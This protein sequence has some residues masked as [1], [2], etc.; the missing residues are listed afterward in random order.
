MNSEK[1]LSLTIL[2]TKKENKRQTKIVRA[3]GKDLKFKTKMT[4]IINKLDLC[5]LI[6]KS[7][8][9]TTRNQDLWEV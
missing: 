6:A 7:I 4:G 3:L 2:P 1:K 9:N 8:H 5:K